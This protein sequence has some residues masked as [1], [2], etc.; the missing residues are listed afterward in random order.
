[1]ILSLSALVLFEQFRTLKLYQVQVLLYQILVPVNCTRYKCFCTRY[2]YLVQFKALRFERDYPSVFLVA[3]LAWR[4]RRQDARRVPHTH[5]TGHPT[6]MCSAS[7]FRRD[8]RLQRQGAFA[9]VLLARGMERGFSREEMQEAA[10][11][12]ACA[13]VLC[14]DGAPSPCGFMLVD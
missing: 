10:H 12:R 2:L 6:G 4:T 13:R 3:Q 11:T 5:R 9:R 8:T 1:M 14:A 7:S